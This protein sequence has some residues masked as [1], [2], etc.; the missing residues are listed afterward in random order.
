MQQAAKTAVTL[1]ALCGVLVLV[2]LWA[3]NAATEPFPGKTDPPLCVSTQVAAGE[4]VFPQQ[5]TVSVYNASDRNGLAGRTID[6]LVDDGFHEGV[7]GNAPRGTRVP[8]AEIWTTTPESPDVRLV[9]TRL[10]KSAEVVRREGMGVGVTVVVGDDFED[11]AK[12]KKSVVAE[13]D[14]DICSPPVS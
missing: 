3:W 2:G 6:L 13:D 12:G 8:L 14:A 4:Q 9:A 7:T 5:V 1:G 11:L 10:G